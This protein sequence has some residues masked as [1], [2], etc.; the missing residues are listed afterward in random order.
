MRKGLPDLCT[1]PVKLAKRLI[2]RQVEP[3]KS[4]ASLAFTDKVRIRMIRR[5]EKNRESSFSLFADQAIFRVCNFHDRP[6]ESVTGIWRN[7]R[8]EKLE[9]QPEEQLNAQVISKYNFLATSRRGR[10]RGGTR[11]TGVERRG[12]P[13]T[14]KKV[15]RKQILPKCC[16]CSS[17]CVFKPR[18]VST[19]QPRDSP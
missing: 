7:L 15:N 19:V 5:E 13:M 4:A 17:G 12:R 10:G 2:P 14:S 6:T 1:W 11:R 8:M 9:Q 3:L 16:F 18:V